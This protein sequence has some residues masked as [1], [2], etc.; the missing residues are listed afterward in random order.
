MTEIAAI[1][2]AGGKSSRMGQDKAL[3]KIGDRPLLY[4]ICT[5]AREC[6]TQVYVV[7]PWIAKYQSILPP[8]CQLIPEKVIGRG[9]LSGFAVG[10]AHVKQEW[11]LLLAC[12][13]P[14]LTASVVKQWCQYLPTVPKSAIALLPSSSK[15]WEPLCGFYRRSCLSA[16]KTYLE[17][18]GTSF[19]SWLANHTVQELPV[20]DR[21]VLFNCNTPEDFHKISNFS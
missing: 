9:P 4:Q 1:V 14:L 17:G 11:I 18:G 13:L 19:Q 2:L 21:Q 6:A 7:T 5:L 12:D 16:L 10:L 15:G 8:N 3:L 20:R